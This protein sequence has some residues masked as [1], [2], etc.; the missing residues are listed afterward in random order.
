MPNSNPISVTVQ[1]G[2]VVKP[3]IESPGNK[4]GVDNVGNN[5]K[6]GV[7]NTAKPGNDTMHA[8]TAMPKENELKSMVSHGKMESPQ[9]SSRRRGR[10]GER[11]P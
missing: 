7:D 3:A 8:P 4:E 1:T 2:G 10:S 6:N 5:I 9:G 11:P